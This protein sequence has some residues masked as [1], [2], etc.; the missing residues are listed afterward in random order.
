MYIHRTHITGVIIAPDGIQKL[1]SAVN[2]SGVFHEQ[3]QKVE[4]LRGQVYLLSADKYTS[5]VEGKL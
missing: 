5:A 3:L 1:F 4:F 2:L